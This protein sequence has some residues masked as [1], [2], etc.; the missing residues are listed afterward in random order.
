MKYIFSIIIAFLLLGCQNTI[1][2]SFDDDDDF[3]DCDY[4]TCNTEEPFVAE[5]SVKFTRN[6][7]NLNPVIY[8]MNGYYDN[9]TIIDSIE[10]D[11]VD[12]NVAKKTLPLNFQYTVFTKYQK[13]AD[14]IIAID[15][16]Y[17]YKKTYQ[18]CDSTCWDIYN[19][20]FNIKLK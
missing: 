8:I 7:E 5:I 10:T 16:A 19:T 17:V 4:S 1:T 14:T 12:G 15:G 20:K 11:T 9:G 3:N 6:S 2:K 13:S 18:E